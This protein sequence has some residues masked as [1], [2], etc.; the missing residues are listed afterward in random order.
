MA[1]GDVETMSKRGQWVN[2]VIGEPERSRSFRTRDEAIDAGRELA[3][4][5]GTEH[6]IIP[7][8]ETGVITDEDEAGA[9]DRARAEEADA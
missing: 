5:L 9:D 4:S 6:R 3:A 1:E 8:E 2:R 7:A